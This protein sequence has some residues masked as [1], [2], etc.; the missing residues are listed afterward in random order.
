M[1]RLSIKEIEAIKSS[2][3]KYDPGAIVYLFG[4]RADPKKRGG[5]IDLVILSQKLKNTDKTKIETTLFEKIEEQ[6][7]DII[8]AKDASQAFVKAALKS[9]VRL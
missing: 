3:F 5:D 1:V 9:G 7:V 4:S 2:I 8:I 6:K